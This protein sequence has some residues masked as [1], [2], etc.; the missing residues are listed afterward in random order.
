MGANERGGDGEAN[1]G[2]GS[3][4]VRCSFGLVLSSS[5]GLRRSIGRLRAKLGR[6]SAWGGSERRGELGG[7]M[8]EQR[9]GRLI[10]ARRASGGHRQVVDRVVVSG[11]LGHGRGHGRVQGAEE[12][13][14]G[15]LAQ[16]SVVKHSGGLE[17]SIGTVTVVDVDDDGYRASARKWRCLGVAGHRGGAGGAGEGRG[18]GHGDER[19]GRPV[20]ARGRVHAGRGIISVSMGASMAGGCRARFRRGRARG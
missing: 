6:G 15:V 13:V 14:T 12:V 5:G 3:S 18:R 1:G 11:W 10:E 2:R 20:W 16:G 7:V 8:K 19:Q 4:G 9:G 17:A